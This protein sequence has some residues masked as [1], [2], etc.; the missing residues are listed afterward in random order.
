MCACVVF[1]QEE[2]KSSASHRLTSRKV[3]PLWIVLWWSVLASPTGPQMLRLQGLIC[4]GLNSIYYLLGASPVVQICL[5]CRKRGF[6]PW[7][8]K[9]P[10]RRKLQPTPVFLPGKSHGQRNLAGYSLWGHKE[11]DTNEWLNNNDNLLNP[12][13]RHPQSVL[14]GSL[15]NNSRKPKKTKHRVGCKSFKGGEVFISG[16]IIMFPCT[17]LYFLRSWHDFQ[18]WD[19]GVKYDVCF[20][21]KPRVTQV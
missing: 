19:P 20:L 11:S 10:R 17:G 5:Q 3:L 16:G 14:A 4:G 2:H 15:M 6:N 7:V 12:R 13:I 9:M 18:A 1:V 21:L 8:G